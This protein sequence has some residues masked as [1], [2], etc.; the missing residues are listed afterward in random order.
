[1]LEKIFKINSNILQIWTLTITPVTTLTQEQADYIGG[2]FRLLLNWN[3]T[4]TNW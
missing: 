4:V 3:T 2:R 1:M